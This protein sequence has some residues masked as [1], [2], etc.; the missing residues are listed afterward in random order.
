MTRQNI[1]QYR[2]ELNTIRAARK[3]RLEPMLELKRASK[4]L[5]S[6]IKMTEAKNQETLHDM[7]QQGIEKNHFK[8]IESAVRNSRP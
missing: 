6:R 2:T 3:E 8:R 7:V 5:K 1:E 4:D